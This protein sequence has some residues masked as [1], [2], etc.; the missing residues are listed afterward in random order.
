MIIYLSSNLLLL[1]GPCLASRNWTT[2]VLLEQFYWEYTRCSW[3]CFV[4]HAKGFTITNDK[5]SL[6]VTWYCK[7]WHKITKIVGGIE[8]KSAIPF[9]FQSIP[10]CNSN[11]NSNSTACNSNSNSNSN[12]G[13]EIGIAINSN[14]NSGI[15]PNPGCHRSQ[16]SWH[17]DN[18]LVSATG[19]WLCSLTHC[20]L[21]TPYSVGDLLVNTGSGNIT[22]TN[23]NLSSVR[24]CGIHLRT[25]S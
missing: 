2:L 18:Y 15:Y 4:L 19:A 5:Q 22:W 23:A 6:L 8:M 14:S 16:Q 1:N 10:S 21:V 3:H 13:I 24:S 7:K 9:Q 17:H 12:S 25:L 11:S 20:G